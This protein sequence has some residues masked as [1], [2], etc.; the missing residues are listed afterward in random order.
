MC[1]GKGVK[2][3]F[4]GMDIGLRNDDGKGSGFISHHEI[5]QRLIS[6]GARVVIVHEFYQH[7]VLGPCGRIGSTKYLEI[8]FYFLVQVQDSFCFA[9]SL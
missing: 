5:E 7:Y 1:C 9:I 2:A 3:G 6:D 4:Y 8:S